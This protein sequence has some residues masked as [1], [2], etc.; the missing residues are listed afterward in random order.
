M[1]P[2]LAGI[3]IILVMK[4]MPEGLAGLVHIKE[5]TKSRKRRRR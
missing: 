5:K 4:F 1:H 3:L 2:I